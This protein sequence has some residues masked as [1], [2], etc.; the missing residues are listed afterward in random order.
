M[1]N[2]IPF[3]YIKESKKLFVTTIEKTTEFVNEKARGIALQL[4]VPFIER[5]KKSIIQLQKKYEQPCIVVGKM[6]TELYGYLSTDPVFFHPNMASIRFKRLNNQEPDPFIEATQLKKGMSMLDC[7]MGMASDTLIA[8]FICGV[9]GKVVGLEINPYLYL[10][11]KDGLQNYPFKSP[12]LKTAAN[13]IICLND[14]YLDYLKKAED[15]SY[16]VVYFDPM[17]TETIHESQAVQT[18]SSFASFE[19]LEQEAISHALRVARKRVV[20]KDYFRSHRFHDF[21]FE[22]DRRKSAKFHYGCIELE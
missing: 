14:D 1:L 12:S 4:G 9:E 6:K 10:V 19:D 22:V 15:N 7:T 18:L 2:S 20:L 11:I 16:D 13:Q 21:G 5:K 8:S 17:F 3:D